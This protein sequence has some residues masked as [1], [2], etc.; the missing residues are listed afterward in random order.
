MSAETETETRR[1]VEAAEAD[2]MLARVAKLTKKAADARRSAEGAIAER[3]VLVGELV[4]AGVPLAQIAS[5]AGVT[6]GALQ[7]RAKA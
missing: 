1:V 6:R 2:A 3:T 5:R 7:W 4:A